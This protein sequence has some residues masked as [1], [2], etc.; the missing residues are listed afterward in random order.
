MNVANS[1]E[2]LRDETPAKL[3]KK[4]VGIILFWVLAMFGGIIPMLWNALA[5]YYARYVPGDL[6][7][8]LLKLLSTA[9]GAILAM[10]ALCVITKKKHAILCIVNNVIAA[11]VFAV[12]VILGLIWGTTSTFDNI[13]ISLA[14]VAF[15]IGSPIIWNECKK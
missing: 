4:I 11:T 5:P 13:S 14:A 10:Y 7:Y 2:L 6:G 15:I 12:V 3:W 1:S 9:I 8:Y